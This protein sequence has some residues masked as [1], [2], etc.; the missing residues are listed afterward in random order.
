MENK[1]KNKF[2]GIAILFLLLINFSFILA[3]ENREITLGENTINFDSNK[4]DYSVVSEFGKEVTAFSF[5]KEDSFV[6]INGIKFEN[7]LPKD[8]SLHPSYIKL[9][10]SGNILEADLTANEKGSVFLINGLTFKAPPNSRV[11]YNK[12]GFF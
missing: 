12:D 3:Q 1:I 9:D 8:K 6:E 2:F 5:N 4:I 10:A 11:Y 7:I